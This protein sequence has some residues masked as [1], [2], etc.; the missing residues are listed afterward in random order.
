MLSMT[1]ERMRLVAT[2]AIECLGNVLGNKYEIQRSGK[3]YIGS[4]AESRLSVWMDKHAGVCWVVTP[5]PWTLE[6]HLITMGPPL[7]LGFRGLLDLK[8][9]PLYRS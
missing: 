7:P 1:L 5:T 6:N 4:D 8:R 3:L 9:A 2:K